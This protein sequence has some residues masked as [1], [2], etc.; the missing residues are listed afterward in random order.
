MNRREVIQSIG[1]SG[2]AMASTGIS[3]AG[4]EEDEDNNI[5]SAKITSSKKVTDSELEELKR[6]ISS[7]KAVNSV[8]GEVK[9]R[10]WVPDWNSIEITRHSV[11]TESLTGTF[12]VAVIEMEKE[13]VK[14]SEDESSIGKERMYLRWVGND[15]SENLEEFH[16][17]YNINTIP[18][19]I[20]G[21][22]NRA[23]ILH[24]ISKKESDNRLFEGDGP[25]ADKI[26]LYNVKDTGNRLT[27][28]ISDD[29]D[30]EKEEIS[31]DEERK[32]KISP[33]ADVCSNDELEPECGGGGSLYCEVEVEMVEGEGWD[34]WDMSCV[35]QGVAALGVSGVSCFYSLGFLCIA[36]TTLTWSQ[37]NDC[38]DCFLDETHTVEIEKEWLMDRRRDLFDEED[39]PYVKSYQDLCPFYEDQSI[40]MTKCD[41]ENEVPTKEDYNY[42]GC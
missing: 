2:I 29:I 12:D 17:K 30:V 4:L 21:E 34:C 35:L 20:I 1:A 41:L 27:E 16:N 3:V 13:D 40:L 39:D 26:I 38:A 24:F 37:L 18:E 8:L 25:A 28:E 15:Q 5:R 36:G 6:K 33:D 32:Q 11:K 19:L 22:S 14:I 23:S 31:L 9:S 7:D 42:P 10:E